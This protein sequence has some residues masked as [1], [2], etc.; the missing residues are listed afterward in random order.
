MK[1]K[2]IIGALLGLG[3]VGGILPCVLAENE[4]DDDSAKPT[5]AAEAK[6]TQAIKA[7]YPDAVIG[8]IGKESEDGIS[9]YEANL[10]VK[11]NKVDVD[12]TS[13]G[14][15][16]ETEAAADLTTFPAPAAAAIKK[17]ADGM[18]ITGSDVITT[19]AKAVKDDSTGDTQ[20][21][22]VVKLAQ[23][24]TSYEV[25]VEKDGNKGD[26]D[27]S[28]DGTVLEMPKWAKAAQ[29]AGA[30]DEEKEDKD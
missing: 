6:I 24:T 1:T 30:K 12:V 7:V 20:V 3:L 4:K 5:P 26:L 8:K 10:T 17:A 2:N 16:I 18:K 21:T 14:T 9:F 11:G 13:D 22:H 25:D 19:Y 15:I 27:V 28:A 23:P 29:K